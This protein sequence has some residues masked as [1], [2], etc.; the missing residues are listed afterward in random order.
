MGIGLFPIDNNLDLIKQSLNYF[1]SNGY[2]S[3]YDSFSISTFCDVPPGTGLGSSST[4]VVS[5]VSCVNKWLNL[6]LDEYGIAKI[7]YNIERVDMDISGGKQDQFAAAFGG[8]N[9]IEF[10]GS[11]KTIVNPIRLKKSIL[12]ELQASILIFNLGT[13]RSSDKIIREQKKSVIKNDKSLASL[14]K[15]KDHAFVMKNAILTGELEK[16]PKILNESWLNKKSLS[17]SISNSSIDNFYNEALKV[18]A[19]AG[20]ISGAGG[21]GVMMLY[22]N[23]VKKL[24]IIKYLEKLG[25]KHIPF[26]F[27]K[28]GC[29]SWKL[30]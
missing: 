26:V 6:N 11:N 15:I 20:K 4:L 18:G 21:G 16:I 28:F 3:K 17:K 5:I 23:P 2:I 22:I 8:F 30:K 19:L 7:A 10:H 13:S 9:F 12:N 25:C 1:V 27:E 24:E 29:Y 14:H